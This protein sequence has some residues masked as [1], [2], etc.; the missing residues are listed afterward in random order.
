MVPR[1]TDRA[2]GVVDPAVHD[3]IGRRHDTADR[4]VRGLQRA[5]RDRRVGIERDAPLSGSD[6]AQLCDVIVRVHHLN[7]VCDEI[8]V[9]GRCVDGNET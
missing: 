9:G 2:K 4:S 8:C 7:P 6:A 3:R 1:R 5:G